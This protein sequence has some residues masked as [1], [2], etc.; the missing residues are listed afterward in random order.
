[1]KPDSHLSRGVLAA[2]APRLW[3]LRV[4][5]VAMTLVIA[6]FTLTPVSPMPPLRVDHSDK[7]SHALGF[8]FW[9]LLAAGAWRFPAWTVLAVAAVFGGMIEIVQPQVGRDA[10]LADLVADLVGAAAGLW[11]ARCLMARPRKDR[12]VRASG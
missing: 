9:A 6:W 12:H 11:V 3:A 5:A 7:L 1:M 8:F 10:E 2:P 4:A